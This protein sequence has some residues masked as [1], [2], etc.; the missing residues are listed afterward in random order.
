MTKYRI[1]ILPG[2]GIVWD[3]PLRDIIEKELGRIVFPINDA[4]AVA[5]RELH[6][7]AGR[8]ALN[9]F[10]IT[11]STGIGGGIIIDG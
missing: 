2:D 3:V 9:F 4:N 8:D 5:L 7:D 10:Y 6:F 11:V 1:P